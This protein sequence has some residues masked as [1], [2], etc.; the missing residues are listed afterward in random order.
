M[1]TKHIQDR[2]KDDRLIV[3]ATETTRLELNI[4]KL[5]TKNGKQIKVHK[6][7][8]GY[9]EIVFATGGETPAEFSGI[10]TDIRAV[11]SVIRRYLDRKDINNNAT[12]PSNKTK[13]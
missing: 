8:R 3:D 13:D 7:G 6:D 1:A 5:E 10:F 2:K 12:K 4:D 9:F 11:A